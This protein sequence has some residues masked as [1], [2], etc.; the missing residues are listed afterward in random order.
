MAE[1]NKDNDFV[2]ENSEM[3][4]ASSENVEGSYLDLV[5]MLV[6][7]EELDKVS[8]VKDLKHQIALKREIE[9]RGFFLGKQQGT[10]D[11]G[12]PRKRRRMRKLALTDIRKVNK[13]LISLV[14]L[15]SLG[16]FC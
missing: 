13:F 14:F 10:A 15:I 11:S 3:F 5:Q 2:S 4:K 1:E 9:K 8:S 7:F 12:S 6:V 16:T